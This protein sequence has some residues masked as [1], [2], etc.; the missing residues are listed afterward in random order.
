MQNLKNFLSLLLFFLCGCASFHAPYNWLT[1]PEKVAEDPYGGWIEVTECIPPEA[2]KTEIKRGELIAIDKDTL[3]LS[4]DAL[5]AIPL[6]NL[7]SARLVKYY[8]NEGAVGALAFLGS[9]STVSN[10]FYLIFT[11]PVWLAG[12]NI[13]AIS[14]SFDPV[15]DYPGEKLSEF[16]PYARFP[17][18]MPAGIDRNLLKPKNHFRPVV[19]EKSTD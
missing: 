18:G 17:Q 19:A 1:M 4:D 7:R 13:A 12:G 16:I 10:G 3:Y 15:I 14:R 5:R 11:F 8:S 9:L 2:A 6:S